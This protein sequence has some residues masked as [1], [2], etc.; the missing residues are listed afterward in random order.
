[1]RVLELFLIFI[2]MYA[3]LADRPSWVP[4]HTMTTE[5][6][7]AHSSASNLRSTLSHMNSAYDA[8][9]APCLPKAMTLRCLEPTRHHPRP[10]G[11]IFQLY[12]RG[13]TTL[14]LR[15]LLHEMKYPAKNIL[16]IERVTTTHA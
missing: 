11:V 2:V 8:H 4:A 9:I 6:G 12:Q 7:A 16:C 3:V 5:R 13:I 1:M 15:L 10:V 14:S